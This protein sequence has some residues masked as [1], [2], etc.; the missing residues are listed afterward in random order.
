MPNRDDI[1][2][3]TLLIQQ[4]F[5]AEKI[6]IQARRSISPLL[7]AALRSEFLIGPD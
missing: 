3:N 2:M 7:P 5:S 6:C 1:A 4:N